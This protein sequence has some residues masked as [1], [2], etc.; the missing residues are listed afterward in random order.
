MIQRIV[1]RLSSLKPFLASTNVTP[2]GP[3]SLLG[4]A[5]GGISMF[6]VVV[7]EV[8]S[9]RLGKERAFV[10]LFFYELGESLLQFLLQDL[11]IIV[12]FHMIV[13]LVIHNL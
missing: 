9:Q 11:H 7:T 4:C 5:V 2:I 3:L 13:L 8:S 6:A 10:V 1:R 12:M